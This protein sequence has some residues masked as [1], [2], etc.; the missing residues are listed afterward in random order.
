MNTIIKNETVNFKTLVTTNCT[1]TNLNFQSKIIDELN[2]TFTDEEQK[3]YIASLYVYLNYHPINDFPINLDDVYK[4]I[5]FVHKKNAK[6]TLINNFTENEDYK[7]NV[8]VRDENVL[9]TSKGKQKKENLTSKGKKVPHG[10]NEIIMLN[11]DTFKN[12]CMITKT[13]KAK[14]IRKYYVKL[15]NIFNK[16]VN[17]EHKQHQLQLQE[18]EQL[19][20]EQK[21][22]NEQKEIELQETKKRLEVSSKLNLK[23]WYNAE[24]CQCVYAFKNDNDTKPNI[25]IGKAENIKKRED[26]YM[27]GNRYSNVFYYKKCYD[28]RLTEK[29]IHHILDKHRIENNKE[30]FEISEELAIYTIDIVCDF[31]D[32]YI[33]CSEELINLKVKEH[34]SITVE[35]ANELNKKPEPDAEPIKTKKTKSKKEKTIINQDEDLKLHFDKFVDE[36]CEKNENNKCIALELL[37]AYRMWLKKHTKKVEL[38]TRPQLTIYLKN[39]YELSHE[40]NTEFNTKFHYYVGIKPKEFIVKQE[41]ENV[42]PHYEEFILSEC[43]VG[44][45]Y[46]IA[47]STLYS[48]FQNW[49]SIKYP[50]YHFSKE[51][52]IHFESYLNRV[53]SNGKVHIF[54]GTNG[55]YGIQM[56]DDTSEKLG[57]VLSKRKKIYKIDIMTNENVETYDSLYVGAFKLKMKEAKLSD[58]VL[59]GTIIDDHYKYSYNYS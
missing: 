13:E 58:L 22:E 26:S 7:I 23:K 56:K 45:T 2:N 48:K 16:L 8:I 3:W 6:L 27:V 15:E 36:Y 51:E 10:N 38:D 52:Q 55:Y 17:E 31:L 34:L 29:V 20:I 50:D 46:R 19:L 28:A 35:K 44:Y 25:K 53:F 21:K 4:L 47:K 40:Y 59:N 42:L 30:W 43:K 5:G 41:K 18:K 49:V 1:N 57:M 12:I 54:G 32:A 9:L 11:V 37:G 39:N 33:G 24:R 14:Q